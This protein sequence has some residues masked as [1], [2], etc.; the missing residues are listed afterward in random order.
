MGVPS[1]PGQNIPMKLDRPMH[2]DAMDSGAEKLNCQTKRKLS[3]LP[4]RSGP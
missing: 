3:Q 2:P 4:A 1:S